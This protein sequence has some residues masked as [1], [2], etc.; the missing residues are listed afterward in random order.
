M[1]ICNSV[2]LNPVLPQIA[3]THSF[4]FDSIRFVACAD[5]FFF[6]H[7]NRQSERK[8][9]IGSKPN[10]YQL[11]DDGKIGAIILQS[12]NSL[13]KC[14]R[15]TSNTSTKYRHRMLFLR[16]FINVNTF[17][18]SSISHF[19]IIIIMT[20]YCNASFVVR[21]R[22]HRSDMSRSRI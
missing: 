20:G 18:F 7:Q 8:S 2:V 13:T 22:R 10:Q 9:R 16:C 5:I 19:I 17:D 12:H 11:H 15:F 21:I 14:C 1:N 4:P 3:N 6:Y